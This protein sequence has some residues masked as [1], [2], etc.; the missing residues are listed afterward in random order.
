MIQKDLMINN[1]KCSEILIK[2]KNK[3]I[4][5]KI[6]NI[7]LSNKLTKKK[8]RILTARIIINFNKEMKSILR[9]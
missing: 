1:N 6:Y 7:K 9:N 4:S 2:I 5:L 8:L 3:I